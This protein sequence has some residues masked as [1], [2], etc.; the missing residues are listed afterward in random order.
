[1]KRVRKPRAKT[2]AGK[3]KTAAKKPV[4]KAASKTKKTGK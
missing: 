2:P 3:S 1:V 4:S